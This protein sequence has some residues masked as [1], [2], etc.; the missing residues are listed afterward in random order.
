MYGYL[1]VEVFV[2]VKQNTSFSRT[3][4][5]GPY[6]FFEVSLISQMRRLR[7]YKVIFLLYITDFP[8]DTQS[9]TD[10]DMGSFPSCVLGLALLEFSVLILLH[11]DL[12]NE[13]LRKLNLETVLTAA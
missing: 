12:R 13:E 7:A 6:I 5:S 10:M 3:T 1:E 9:V 8:S 2:T 11:V 4:S